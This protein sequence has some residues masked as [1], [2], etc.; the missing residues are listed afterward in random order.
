MIKEF[1]FYHGVVF[2]KIIHESNLPISISLYPTPSNSS[3]TLNGAI[4]I[5]VKYSTKRLSPWRFSF[6]KEHQEEVLEMKKLLNEVFLVF[7][8]G[9]D[10][11]ASL[12]SYE[13][14]MVLNEIHKDM[15]WVSLARNPRQEYLVKGSDGKLD[16]KISQ[17]NSIRR[18]VEACYAAKERSIVPFFS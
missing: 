7:V 17:N 6:K 12:N 8:C 13:T 11:V 10:G 18:I 16:Y 3:Y 5:Y 2:S 14:R 1:E 9:D 4:G 15:E